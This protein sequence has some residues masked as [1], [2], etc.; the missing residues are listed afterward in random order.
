M[1]FT[2]VCNGIFYFHLR[3][4]PQ[5]SFILFAYTEFLQSL[6]PTITELFLVLCKNYSSDNLDT[7]NSYVL[8]CI[9]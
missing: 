8:Y 6:T 3:K 9:S 4:S 5:L 1:N 7:G 2:Q